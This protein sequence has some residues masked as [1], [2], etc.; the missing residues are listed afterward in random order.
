MRRTRSPLPSP[1]PPLAGEGTA[2][3]FP[4]TAQGGGGRDPRASVGGRGFGAALAALFLFT[5][6][7]LTAKAHAAELRAA[8]P[9]GAPLETVYDHA[10]QACEA[11]DVPDAPA[12]AWKGAD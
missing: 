7:L 10:S 12:R 1:P 3:S 6:P 2:A 8:V 5:F 4:S 9:P 11:W